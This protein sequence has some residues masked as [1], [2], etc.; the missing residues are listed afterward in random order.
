MTP[1]EIR[2]YLDSELN[3]RMEHIVEVT[4]QKVFDRMYEEIG[5]SIVKRALWVL[6]LGLLVLLGWLA[7]K[8]FLKS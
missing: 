5:K 3:A 2:Q 6:G 8:G 4:V 1:E 7:G